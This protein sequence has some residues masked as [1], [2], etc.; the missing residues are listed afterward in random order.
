LTEHRDDSQMSRFERQGLLN[1]GA[2]DAV[3]AVGITAVLCVLLSGG[4]VKDAAAQLD[5]GIGR[6]LVDA[7]G[8]PTGWIAD[9]FPFATATSELTSGLSPDEELGGG[10]FET[11]RA[12]AGAGSG[13]S[14][15]P[16][17][18]PEAFDPAQ[19]G[20]Q[21]PPKQEL[22]TMLVT[23]DSLATPLDTILA[24]RLAADGVEVIRDPH[25]GTGISNSS[26]VDWGR[27]STSQ[28]G[29][30]HPDAVVV[31]IGATEGFP[32]P[33]PNGD[34]QCCGPEYAAAYANRV[35][36]V[37]NTFRQNGE[38]K[39]YWLTVMTPRDPDSQ[40]V[41]RMLNAAI[42]VAAEPWRSQVRV[43]DTVPIFTPGYEYSDAIDVD[44][45]ETIVRES[46]GIHLN[47]EGSEI[48]ADAVLDRV[49]QDFMP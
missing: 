24:R 10:A 4:S 16:P 13:G 43:I 31:F 11:A 22:D 8:E 14:Q 18:T 3:K 30:Y 7:V 1:L 35:R 48:A 9:R 41:M 28:V 47:E 27:L 32:L 46:D 21:P 5:S 40:Q 15:V 25:L 2:W 36:Q 33:G 44:G 19:I 39:V 20:A 26:L 42:E 34:I 6:D 38:A 29:R 23:G 17:V 49:D 12:G 37:M 45:E